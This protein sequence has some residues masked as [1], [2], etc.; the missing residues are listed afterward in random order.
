MVGFT[1][2]ELYKKFA[3]IH[4]SYNIIDYRPYPLCKYG[5]I[6]WISEGSKYVEIAYQYDPK[7]DI[8][9]VIP[10]AKTYD[11]IINGQ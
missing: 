9:T 7:K 8:F 6:V 1:Y 11:E 4:L 5:I 10:D 2:G 3:K